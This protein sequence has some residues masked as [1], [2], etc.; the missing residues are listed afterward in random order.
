[1]ISVLPR[2]AQR[3]QEIEMILNIQDGGLPLSAD[4]TTENVDNLP[5]VNNTQISTE[6][7]VPVG[8]SLLV[9]GYSRNQDEH[10]SVG[11][12]LLRDIPFIGGLFDYSYTSHKK[13]VRLFLIQPGLLRNGET[14]QGRTE[15][16]PVL[17]R[18]W[19]GNEVTLKSTVSM[20]RETMKNN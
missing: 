17:G 16:N 15:I 9:G 1:M 5:T 7:R 11:I 13:M 2:L 4:G 10:H 8:Y 18:T 6:A 19:V 3:Q 12:P 14:W 20:L